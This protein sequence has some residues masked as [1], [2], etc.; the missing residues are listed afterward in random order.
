MLLKQL[1]HNLRHFLFELSRVQARKN[2]LYVLTLTFFFQILSSNFLTSNGFVTFK[3]ILMT[4]QI[5]N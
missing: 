4:K 3:I 5:K 2:L 1:K